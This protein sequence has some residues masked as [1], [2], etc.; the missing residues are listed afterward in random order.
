MHLRR[1]YSS[2]TPAPVKSAI[3]KPWRNAPRHA[4]LQASIRIRR[5]WQGRL[6][7]LRTVS[8]GYIKLKAAVCHVLIIGNGPM[9]IEAVIR[10]GW[11]RISLTRDDEKRD[12]GQA[13]QSQ[14]IHSDDAQ[15]KIDCRP[16]FKSQ[17]DRQ[18]GQ[19][20]KDVANVFGLGEC[21]KPDCQP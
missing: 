17:Y 20:P 9:I 8:A 3:L 5:A 11:Q 16:Y 15:T 14:S 7:T 4:R 13:E 12:V 18:R 2:V 6:P 19:A 10:P 1:H 21:E